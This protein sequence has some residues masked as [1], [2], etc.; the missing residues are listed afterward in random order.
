MTT[1]KHTPAVRPCLAVAFALAAAVN[2]HAQSAGADA[3]R[4][5]APVPASTYRSVLADYRPAA[6]A[7]DAPPA[8]W[9]AANAAV[10]GQGGMH[11]MAGHAMEK[12][13][14]SAPS[15]EAEEHHHEH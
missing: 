1:Q 10:A 4:A 3:S 13:P 12:P 7:N 11:G 14:A 9:T 6:P 2:A 15:P 5:D 8:N